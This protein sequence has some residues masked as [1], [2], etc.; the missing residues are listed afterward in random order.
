MNRK[1]TII[2]AAFSILLVVTM[3]AWAKQFVERPF[4]GHGIA[5]IDEVVVTD[6]GNYWSWKDIVL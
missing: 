4:K 1:K 6:E 3:F 5:R 2:I